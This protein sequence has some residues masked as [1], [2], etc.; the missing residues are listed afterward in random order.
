MRLIK[1]NRQR[2]QINEIRNERGEV[3]TDITEIQRNVRK[4]Y[5]QLHANKLDN[6]GEM[7][8]FLET[9]SLQKLNQEVPENQNRWISTNEMKAVIK[10]LPANKSPVL[11]GFTGELYQSFK[12]KLTHILLKLFQKIQKERI[13]PSS[14]YE[15]SIILTPKPDKD[16]TQKEDCRSISVLADRSNNT[17]KRS[18]TIVKW[19][20]FRACKVATTF[21]NQ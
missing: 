7:D 20:L 10:K 15:Y 1:K 2:T 4:Y 11:D 12:E 6:L 21:T 17:L 19:D 5:E 16:T 18:Y 8:K 3:T 14:F 13:L 9:C